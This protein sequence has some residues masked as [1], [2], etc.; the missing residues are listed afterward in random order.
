MDEV[1]IFLTALRQKNDW[2][3][4]TVIIGISE[5]DANKL[6]SFV[7]NIQWEGQTSSTFEG[8]CVISGAQK[9]VIGSQQARSYCDLFSKLLMED[10]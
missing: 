1:H 9:T 10:S 8:D 4:K 6:D 5:S 3:N 7:L 2:W